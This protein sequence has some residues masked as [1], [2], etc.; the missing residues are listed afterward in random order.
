[1]PDLKTIFLQDDL[2]WKLFRASVGNADTGILKSLC[3]LFDMY[4]DHIVAKLNQIVWSKF[5]KDVQNFD[6]LDKT[7]SFLKP[8]TFLANKLTPSCKT[9]LWLRFWAATCIRL[10]FNL[11]IKC[12]CITIL[13]VQVAIFVWNIVFIF[14]MKQHVLLTE[15]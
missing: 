6:V 1:M 8:H 12:V 11:C 4:L 9:F 5:L 7:P 10:E 14:I 13:L 15:V 2:P 3:S